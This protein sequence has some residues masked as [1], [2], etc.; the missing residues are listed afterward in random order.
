MKVVET[1]TLM[2]MCGV[3]IVIYRSDRNEYIRGS[4]GIIRT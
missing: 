1:R 4:L 3:T 2:C